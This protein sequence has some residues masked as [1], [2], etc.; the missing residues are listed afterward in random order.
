MELFDVHW[1]VSLNIMGATRYVV[2]QLYSV[3]D[4]FQS[5]LTDTM[6]EL[7]FYFY[8]ANYES[9]FMFLWLG[10]F[11]VYKYLY[12]AWIGKGHKTSPPPRHSPGCR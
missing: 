11:I 3:Q 4:T 10:Q 9:S 12:I 6:F 7:L 8:N 5:Y 2:L 1:S